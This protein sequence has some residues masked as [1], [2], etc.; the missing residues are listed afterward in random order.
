[1]PTVVPKEPLLSVEDR[2]GLVASIVVPLVL[3]GTDDRIGTVPLPA[4][5]PVPSSRN[6]DLRV[7]DVAESN[8]KHQIPLVLLDDLG[9]RHAGL[10]PFVS[11]IGVEDGIVGV[12]GPIQPI[13][14]GPLAERI[15][16]VLF[17]ARIPELEQLGRFVPDDVGAHHRHFLPRLVRRKRRLV[18]HAFPR[19]TVG[20]GGVADP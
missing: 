5:D 12:L 7:I 9:G 17:A 14:A 16:F 19:E 18:A 20:A 11:R 3:A 15:R 8:V 10:F 1:M 4:R 2:V 13:R 6:A